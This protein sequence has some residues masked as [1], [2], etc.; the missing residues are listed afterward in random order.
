MKV[1]SLVRLY[2]FS[3]TKTVIYYDDVIKFLFHCYV[4]RFETFEVV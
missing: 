2:Q 4:R 1:K 3:E